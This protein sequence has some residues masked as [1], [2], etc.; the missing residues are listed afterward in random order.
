MPVTSV[1]NSLSPRYAPK[2]SDSDRSD[3]FTPDN[4]ENL[5]TGNFEETEDVIALQSKLTHAKFFNRKTATGLA[6]VSTFLKYHI[7][8]SANTT[9]V[10]GLHCTIPTGNKARGEFLF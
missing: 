3:T 5:L 10:F 8:V 4:L 9:A 7:S 1:K 2:D 6:D